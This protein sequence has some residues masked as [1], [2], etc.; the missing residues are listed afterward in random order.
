LGL[1]PC[2][3]KS[4]PA[5]LRLRQRSWFTRRHLAGLRQ[6]QELKPLAEPCQTTPY[7]TSTSPA[8]PAWPHGRRRNNVAP[9]FSTASQGFNFSGTVIYCLCTES[10]QFIKLFFSLLPQNN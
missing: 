7:F 3:T 10:T 4:A 9:L 2:S 5:P 1:R 8:A 6:E